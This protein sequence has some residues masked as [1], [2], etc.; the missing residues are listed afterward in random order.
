MHVLAI[1]IKVIIILVT[2]EETH[3]EGRIVA[4]IFEKTE[5]KLTKKRQF[6]ATGT[7]GNPRFFCGFHDLDHVLEVH[8]S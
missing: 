2:L 4:I 7:Y 8:K 6:F 3:S 5:K 1:R